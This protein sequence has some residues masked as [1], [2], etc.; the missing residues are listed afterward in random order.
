MLAQEPQ[1]SGLSASG[2]F[3]METPGHPWEATVRFAME[4]GKK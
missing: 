4:D 1:K 2:A 3:A